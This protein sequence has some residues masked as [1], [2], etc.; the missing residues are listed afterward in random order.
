MHALLRWRSFINSVAIRGF[1]GIALPDLD[2]EEIHRRYVSTYIWKMNE[3]SSASSVIDV[4]SIT[5]DLRL[6]LK[7][8]SHLHFKIRGFF[9]TLFSTKTIFHFYRLGRYLYT[10]F[11]SVYLCNG[12]LWWALLSSNFWLERPLQ[13]NRFR[14][15]SCVYIP[16]SDTIH[17]I[18]RRSW[19]YFLYFLSNSYG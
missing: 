10:E 12:T 5:I 1:Q 2:S 9:S 13:L 16:P 3:Y 17:L 14:I 7:T 18:A 8:R 4:V 11:C 19:L 15:S 6:T